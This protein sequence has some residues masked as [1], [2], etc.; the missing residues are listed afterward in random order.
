MKKRCPF[1][2]RMPAQMDKQSL[3]KGAVGILFLTLL[4]LSACEKGYEDGPFERGARA[5]LNGWDMW[6]QDAVRPYQDP[7]PA[8]PEGAVPTED[9][10]SFAKGQKD[11]KPVPADKRAA[12]GALTYRRYCHHCHGPNGDGR[13][14]VGESHEFKPADL[15]RDKVQ[16][17]SDEALFKHLQEGGELMLPLAATLSPVEMLLVIGHIRTLEDNPSRPYYNPQFTEPIR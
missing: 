4:L 13:I 3:P 5:A 16:A 17:K 14:I 9:R 1:I 2:Q 8:T 7:M 11:L 15:R 12:K 6:D 10:F